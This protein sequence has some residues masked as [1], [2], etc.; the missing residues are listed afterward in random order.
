MNHD[1]GMHPGASKTT[2]D[3][4]I[5]ILS[6]ATMKDAPGC[7]PTAAGQRMPNHFNRKNIRAEFHDYSGGNYFVTI[8]TRDKLHYF[9]EIINGEMHYSVIGEFARQALETLHTHYNYVRVP[10]FVVMPNHVHAIIT[11]RESADAPGCIPTIRTALGVV[12]GGYK[13]SVTRYAR[14]NSI[15]FGWQGRYHDHIIRGRDDGDP[16]AEY[17]EN[18]IARWADDCFNV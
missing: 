16:I 8:C 14:R 1:V 11:I 10:L 7:I 6:T 2:S 17:I 4:S 13:Q 15:E 3:A 12:V 5:G 9:G 18:N